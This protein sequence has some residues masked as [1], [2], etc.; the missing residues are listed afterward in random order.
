MRAARL[1]YETNRNIKAYT[2]YT[3]LKN[4]T[5]S[6]VIHHYD[7]QLDTLI[8]GLNIS[9]SAFYRHL[10]WAEDLKLISRKDGKLKL[11][12]Y[13]AVMNELFIHEKKFTTINYD[14]DTDKLHLILEVLE[15]SE[16]KERQTKAV[17]VKISKHPIVISAFKLF[18]TTQ[19][20]PDQAFNLANLQATQKILFEKGVA[21]RIYN[22][23]MYTVNPDF[24]RCS[25]TIAAAHNYKSPRLVTYYKRKLVRA[26][27]IKVL[28]TTAPVCLY[29]KDRIEGHQRG[30]NENASYTPYDPKSRAKFWFKPDQIIIKHTLFA[31]T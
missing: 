25:A 18:W 16:N 13:Q 24:S 2:L 17:E 1:K 10:S 30:K 31:K 20:K 27:L 3:W 21:E 8:A 9:R 14:T 5:E 19:G 7:K 11:C 23:L 28:P 12:S 29:N 26:G 4:V 6:G 15:G 22:P